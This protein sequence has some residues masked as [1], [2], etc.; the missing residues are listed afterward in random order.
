M[1]GS[2]A[3]FGITMEEAGVSHMVSMRLAAPDEPQPVG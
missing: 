2:D 3:L 1:E